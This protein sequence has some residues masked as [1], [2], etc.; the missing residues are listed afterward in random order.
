MA[1][2]S[3]LG[4]IELTRRPRGNS[5]AAALTKASSAPLTRLAEAPERIGSRLRMP[6]V[7]V[8]EP[9]SLMNSRPISSR[10]TW[11]ISLS[12]RPRAKCSAF[13][14]SR[15]AKV[16]LPAAQTRA[17]KRPVCSN[18]RRIEALSLMST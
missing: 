18:R 11:P 5:M 4:L 16:T 17:S 6:L 9:P 2:T 12:L 8:N 10:L 3:T 13:I 1:S 14:S 7:K 15:G